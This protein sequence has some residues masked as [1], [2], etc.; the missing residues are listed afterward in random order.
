LQKSFPEE[1]D[2]ALSELNLGITDIRKITDKQADAIC[3]AIG[4]ILDK[5]NGS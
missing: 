3:V 5:E 4:A 1:C 2:Q